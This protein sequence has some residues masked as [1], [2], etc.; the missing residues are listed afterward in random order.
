METMSGL[1]S[2]SHGLFFS[3]SRTLRIFTVLAGRGF[4]V[5]LVLP[6]LD[7]GH[8]ADD[9]VFVDQVLI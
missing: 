3:A 9:R 6:P 7:G 8:P 4:G 1:D 5:V 2:V